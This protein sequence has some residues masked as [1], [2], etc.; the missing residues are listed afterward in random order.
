VDY[1]IAQVNIGKLRAP[2]GSARLGAAGS[3]SSR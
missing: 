3:G 2:L 1:L